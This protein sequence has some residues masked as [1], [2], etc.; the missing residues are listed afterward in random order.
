MR[1]LLPVII[2]IACFTAGCSNRP[3]GTLSCSKMESVLYD[4][5]LM[6][7]IIDQIPSNE[8][9]EKAQDYMNAVYQKHDITEAQFDQSI[10]YYN[11]NPKD[12]H[13]IYRNLK[14]RYTAQSEEIKLINGNND[15]MAVFATG[16]DTTNLWNST[17]LIMLRNNELQNRE[18]FTIHADTT[19]Y[20]HDQF[21]F[22]ITPVFFNE[23]QGNHENNL[24]IGLSLQYK[25]GKTIGTTRTIRDNRTHQLTLQAIDDEDIEKI[26]GFIYYIGKNN[27]RNMCLVNNISLVRM[28]E[29]NS[30]TQEHSDTL[31]IDTLQ[32]DTLQIDSI[33]IDTVLQT[34]ERRMTP[35][36]LRQQNKTGKRIEIKKAPSVRTPNTIGPKRRISKP[37]N[38]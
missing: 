35:E 6:Q 36:E 17:R 1:K 27:T 12:L 13:Q 14:K 33:G 5:H 38:Q 3:Q 23:T 18:S 37:A 19:F 2:L 34:I 28:H 4:F 9:I 31:Q 15:M 29:K 22:T 24:N 30:N 25:N 20:Q 16:G 21:I 26:T 32:I 8:R 10:A 11:R 7:G